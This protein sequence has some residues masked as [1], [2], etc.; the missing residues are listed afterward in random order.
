MK[1]VL[2]LAFVAVVIAVAMT[3]CNAR[4]V[5]KEPSYGIV[6]IPHNTNAWPMKYRDKADE[7]MRK[8][9]PDG[10]E[11]I[12]EEEVVVGQQTRFSEDEE[13]ADVEIIDGILSVGATERRGTAT[14]TDVTEYHIHY[15]PKNHVPYTPQLGS[16]ATLIR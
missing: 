5:L 1:R 2:A 10:F 13:H 11:V 6:S 16:A 15:V 14:T 8:H 12:R 7:V 9:F 4:Q 3:G